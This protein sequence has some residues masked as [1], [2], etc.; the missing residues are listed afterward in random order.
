MRNWIILAVI[1]FLGF[2]LG[3]QYLNKKNEAKQVEQAVFSHP[4]EPVGVGLPPDVTGYARNKGQSSS[5]PGATVAPGAFN[6]A[7]KKK[8][9]DGAV[10]SAE[11]KKEAERRKKA[12]QEENKRVSKNPN[13]IRRPGL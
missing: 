13:L 9:A 8:Q 11:E 1:A 6:A 7:L 12:I 2:I 3:L 10:L 4:S 5:D